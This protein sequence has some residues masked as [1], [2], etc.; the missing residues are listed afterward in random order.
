[1]SSHFKKNNTL[2]YFENDTV[3]WN[4]MEY[5]LKLKT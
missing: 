5:V 4:T 2:Y 3:S 1:M